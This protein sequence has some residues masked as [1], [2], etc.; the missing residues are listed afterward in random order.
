M[1]RKG[2]IFLD[3]KWREQLEQHRNQRRE[4]IIQGAQQLF[5]ERGLSSVTLKDIVTFCGISKVTLYKYFRSLDEIIFEVQINVIN[6]FGRIAF[7]SSDGNNGYEKIRHLLKNIITASEQH[8][9]LVRFIAMFDNL[10]TENYVNE[11]L[12]DRYI[13]FLRSGK[14]PYYAL[15]EEGVSDGSIR[16]DIDLYI[17]TYTLSNVVSATLQ[18]TIIR[19]KVLQLEGV[20]PGS[21]LH[22]M[23]DMALTYLKPQGNQ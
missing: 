2:R 3:A 18:R 9:D 1:L 21:I 14:H 23:L 12:G 17:L 11:E 10:Y 22:H 16:N 8:V 15:L 6:A 20:E 13:S 7:R 19:S 5:L 4:D